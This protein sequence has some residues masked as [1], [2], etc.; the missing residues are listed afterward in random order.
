MKT[1]NKE[2]LR[3]D[4]NSNEE[5]Y[6]FSLCKLEDDYSIHWTE[7]LDVKKDHFKL[8]LHI[9]NFN[10]NVNIKINKSIEDKFIDIIFD[11]KKFQN[12]NIYKDLHLKNIMKMK[13]NENKKK[14]KKYKYTILK[15]YKEYVYS[16]IKNNENR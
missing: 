4:K 8:K 15:I 9:D 3:Y 14:N 10:K 7:R 5:K 16:F 1:Y 12:L 6:T 11:F 13:I 2:V